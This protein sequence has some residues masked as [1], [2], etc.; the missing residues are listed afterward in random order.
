MNDFQ[1]GV[2]AGIGVCVISAIIV[3]GIVNYLAAYFPPIPAC[4]SLVIEYKNPK[5]YE[6]AIISEIENSITNSFKIRHYH[7]DKHS[8]K[9]VLS[10]PLEK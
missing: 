3:Y 6:R 8:Y 2:G 5:P 4:E 7:M 10:N 9:L 1:K